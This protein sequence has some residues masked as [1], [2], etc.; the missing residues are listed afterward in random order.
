MKEEHKNNLL[1]LAKYLEKLPENY[2][3]FNTSRYYQTN[4][5]NNYPKDTIECNLSK[6]GSSA[7]AL[8]HGILAGIPWP[9]GKE[10]DWY[11]YGKEQ[12]GIEPYTREW[13]FLF[14]VNWPN[15]PKKAAERIYYLL[16]GKDFD[17]YY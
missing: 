1:T 17:E 7:C 4:I 13:S 11:S 16:E 12:F 2:E 6:C 8:G 14:G 10:G 9:E 3:H 5:S 15:D